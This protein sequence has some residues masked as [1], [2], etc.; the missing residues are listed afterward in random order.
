M[1]KT[2]RFSVRVDADPG[3]VWS[4][5]VEPDRL[6]QW[7]C[8]EA[9]I[10]LPNG[11]FRFGGTSSPGVLG[12]S[13]IELLGYEQERSLRF[14]WRVLDHDT[15]VE[16]TLTTDDET[17][18]VE[19]VHRD[20]PVW[21]PGK[22]SM[23]DY[24]GLALEHLRLHLAGEREL[25]LPDL[26]QPASDIRLDYVFNAPADDVFRGLTEPELL[27]KVIAADAKVDL[28]EGGNLGYGWGE[29]VGPST[30]LE[31]KPDE[32]LSV[33][34]SAG[35]RGPD[36]VVTWML[37]EENGRTRVTLVHSGF[38][39]RTGLDHICGWMMYLA[40]LRALLRFGDRWERV[41]RE[42]IADSVDER[43]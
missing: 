23:D 7:F 24:W 20:F 13:G 42:A 37:E 2:M 4:A 32:R 27:N 35:E 17:T 41:R 8:E 3:S 22:F 28:R 16:I 31:L 6:T 1:T 10:D 40:R 9:S 25:P 12:P 30:I 34:W 21:E 43:V 38:G 26:S 14:R 39:D 36:T 5:L 11:I 19:I 29:R 18:S 15:T 33:Q